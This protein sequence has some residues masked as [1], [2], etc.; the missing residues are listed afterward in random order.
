MIPPSR[1]C[2]QLACGMIQRPSYRT[3]TSS[4][5]PW[6]TLPEGSPSSTARTSY[7]VTTMRSGL[8]VNPAVLTSDFPYCSFHCLVL[9][10]VLKSV[11][12]SDA[13]PSGDLKP[14]NI[15]LKCDSSA[16]G[17]IQCKITE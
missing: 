6:G 14:E 1:M 4:W 11:C 13:R 16:P 7:M 9:K 10:S 17:K 15:M 3:W 12:L 8:C 2:W 5:S